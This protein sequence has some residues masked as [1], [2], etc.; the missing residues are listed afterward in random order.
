MTQH[1]R[2][3]R[4]RPCA[5]CGSPMVYPRSHQGRRARHDQ[6]PS[7]DHILPAA[8]GGQWADDNL[9][10]C[11]VGCNGLRAM[12]GHCPAALACARDV[13]RATRLGTLHILNRWKLVVPDPPRLFATSAPG[14][15]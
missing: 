13:G 15:I 2:R 4:G 3:H 8:W 1:N 9:R 5:Y 11:C 6:M 12:A 7:R 10:L 14:G